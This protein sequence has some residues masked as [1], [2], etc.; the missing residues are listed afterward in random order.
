VLFFSQNTAG[1]FKQW[2]ITLGS[3][4]KRQIFAERFAKIAEYT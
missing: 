2:I 1:F 3:Q 4:G